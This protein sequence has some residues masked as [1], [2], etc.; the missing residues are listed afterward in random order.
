MSL[1]ILNPTR[2]TLLLVIW[3]AHASHADDRAEVQFFES[4]I[5]PVLAAKCYSCHSAKADRIKGDYL[6]DTRDGIRKG[7]ASKRDAVIPGDVEGSQLIE[8]IRYGNKKLQMPPDSK[9]S[10]SV[11]ADLEKWIAMG[12]A[13]PRDGVSRLPREVVAENHWAWKRPIRQ[14]PPKVKDQDWARDP[15]DQFVLAKLEANGMAPS[16]DVDRRTLIRRVT[17][18]LTGLPPTI[19]AIS[20]FLNDTSATRIAFGKVV[21]CLLAD[22]GFGVRWGRHWL[23]VARYGESSGY[24]RNMLY[25]YAWRYRN[26]VIDSFNADKPFDRF[27]RE[28]IA[29]DL[30]PS[31]DTRQADDQVLGTGFLTMGAKTFN[32]GNIVLFHLNCADDQIDVTCRAFLGLTV[33]CARCHDHKY[34]PIPTADY[35]SMAGIFLSS[36]NLAGSETNVRNEHSEA[37][38]LGAAGFRRLQDIE[39]AETRAAEAQSHYISLVKIRNTLREPLIKNGVDWKKNPTPEL[40]EAEAKVQAQ[41]AVVKATK[42]NIPAPPDYAMAVVEGLNGKAAEKFDEFIKAEKEEIAAMK[43]AQK[44]PQD[45]TPLRPKIQDSPVYDKGLHDSPLD[46]VKRGGLSLFDYQIKPIKDGESGRLQLAEWIADP[47]NPLTAR[48]YVNR[49]WRHLFGR[50]LVET[51]DNFGVL[52]FQPSHQG[53]LDTLAQD[54]MCDG[55]STKKLVRR[56]VMSR[57]YCQSSAHNEKYAAKDTGNV[58]LWRYSPQLLEGEVIRDSILHVSGTLDPVHLQTS[59]V[60]EISRQQALGR[61]REIGR[62][63]YYMKDVTWD[64]HHRSAYLPMPR[65]VIPDVLATFDAADPNLVVGARKLTIVPTQALYLANSRMVIEESGKVAKR[66]LAADV[67]ARL[68]SAYELILGRYPE[69]D[70]QSAVMKFVD[71]GDDPVKTWTRVCQTLIC[72]GEFRTLY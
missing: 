50:G 20:Y 13:D 72:S 67:S 10:G 16:S 37:Y 49:V 47:R 61:Q 52:G 54:F 57:T 12:A 22:S 66:V 27:I 36:R 65:G 69:P 34:D 48:V 23:D 39:D 32:E 21:D 8:A 24:S 40:K 18:E 64:V 51:V 2:I 25:P 59:Q 62:R 15:I 14:S 26:Y 3:M 46:T 71:A 63:D 1:S 30:L 5:R 60:A 4:K 41:Q 9:L 45:P 58:Y 44:R 7:G 31:T 55:W 6:L 35:Y 11:I 38:P 53:L 33:N 19:E 68:D 70:E 42:T 43:K 29:G 17:L 28:Q 56:I